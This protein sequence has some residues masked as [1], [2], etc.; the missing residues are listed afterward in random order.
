MTASKKKPPAGS[1][2]RFAALKANLA[3]KGASDPSAL[4]AYIGRRKFGNKKFQAMAAA[5]RSRHSESRKHGAAHEKGE[6]AKMRAME[7]KKGM[8]S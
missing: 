7:K 4:A 2:K 3:K 5:G 6:G 1:G 8:R